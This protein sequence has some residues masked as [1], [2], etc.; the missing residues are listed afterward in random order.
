MFKRQNKKT[1]K[2][3]RMESIPDKLHDFPPSLPR[4]T[5]IRHWK[6]DLQRSVVRAAK[7]DGKHARNWIRQCWPE[8]DTPDKDLRKAGK[9][10][11]LDN[12]VKESL[13]NVKMCDRSVLGKRML[14]ML[15]KA[16]ERGKEI[17]GRSWVRYV[18]L[19]CMPDDRLKSF[20]DMSHLLQVTWV[21]DS[22]ME[23]FLEL[24]DFILEG[25]DPSKRPQKDVLHE[26]LWKQFKKTNKLQYDVE[27]YN[28]VKLDDP[29]KAK[30]VHTYKWL[31]RRMENYIAREDQDA[32]EHDWDREVSRITGHSNPAAAGIG[33]MT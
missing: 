21:G 19:N 3:K 11:W 14:T 23:V 26:I 30:K 6:L 22:K 24:F 13:V 10:Y 9:F 32:I 29:K 12:L 20:F 16:E 33:Y 25:M 18:L 31:R 5:T 1:S 8:S 17:T 27:Y 2:N 28:R 7:S 15:R 4:S